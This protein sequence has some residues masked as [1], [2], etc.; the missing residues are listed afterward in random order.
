MTVDVLIVTPM[1]N[2]W[3]AA[4]RLL[5]HLSAL[6]GELGTRLSAIVVDDGSTEDGGFDAAFVA[7]LSGIAR[8]EVVE[9][10]ANLGHARA[11]AVGLA[12]AAKERA[13]GAVVVMDSD[14]ED[15]PDDLP[16][17]LEA[18]RRHPAKVIVGNRDRRSEGIVFR[19][20]YRLY[21]L[22][23]R[24][25]TSRAISFGNFCLIPW[26]VLQKLIFLPDLWTHLAASIVHARLPM[27]KLSTA[28][29]R[30]YDGRSKMNL[31]SLVQHG[32]GAIAVDLDRV[33]VRISLALMAFV[34]ILVVAMLTVVVIRFTTDLAIPGW[35]S[36]VLGI[37]SILVVQSIVFAVLL[38]FIS[39]KNR[40]AQVAVPALHYREFIAGVTVLRG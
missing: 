2:D 16:R 33:L 34:L 19:A 17:L 30:R 31:V 9:L 5:T 13:A 37:L 10:V 36:N 24:A 32:L 38:L 11:I 27:A 28:R 22:L 14:G 7:T 1:Y 35:A 26:P 21:K 8:L 15:R 18:S 39:L 6:A 25:L 12:Y 4:R 29:G 23:F 20:C 40:G 3:A